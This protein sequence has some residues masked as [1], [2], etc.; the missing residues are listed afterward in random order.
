M[1]LATDADVSSKVSVFNHVTFKNSFQ[2][3][4]MAIYTTF[5]A[6]HALFGAPEGKKGNMA[7]SD[8]RLRWDGELTRIV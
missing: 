7:Q 3:V 5:Q 8:A 6:R 1:F 2:G 4:S